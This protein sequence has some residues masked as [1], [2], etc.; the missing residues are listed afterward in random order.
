MDG[1][2]GRRRGRFWSLRWRA[3]ASL[4]PTGS[5]I[6]RPLTR[7]LLLR[8]LAVFVVVIALQLGVTAIATDQPRRR[9]AQR[10]QSRDVGDRRSRRPCPAV[11][12]ACCPRSILGV[13]RH[14]DDGQ[15]R[16]PTTGLDQLGDLI[17]RT[18][19]AGVRV[20]LD[21]DES[22]DAAA[23]P[24]EIDLAAY[25][26]VQES[27]TNVAR[28]ADPA[29]AVVRIRVADDTLEIDV[30]DEGVPVRRPHDAAPSGGNGIA[31]MTERAASVGGTLTTGPRPGRGFAVRARLP[32]G[33][34]S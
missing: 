18:E 14:V 17:R 9:P 19:T 3:M 11:V 21:A 7:S 33:G 31:G 24:R 20:R 25:R 5:R 1:T 13:L 12:P 6:R 10:V 16:R 28:H 23:L 8:E 15:P 29:D 2:P 34:P 22:L 4:E 26:I 30:L 27:L 32:I